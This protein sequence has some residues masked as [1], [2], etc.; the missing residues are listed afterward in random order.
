M[1]RYNEVCNLISKT[2]EQDDEGVVHE[3]ATSTQVFCNPYT[4]GTQGWATARLADYTAD[5]ELQVRTC[6]YD[7]QSDVEYDGD[8]FS[9][10]QVMVQGDFTRLMLERR[11]ADEVVA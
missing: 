4:V 1:S 7:G 3:T 2:M 5:A 6:D 8:A 9:V 11:L 10:K